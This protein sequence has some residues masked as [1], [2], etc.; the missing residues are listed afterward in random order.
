M[1]D[2]KMWMKW[3][4]PVTLIAF[5]I[6]LTMDLISM[7]LWDIM[8]HGYD[9]S[10]NALV[11]GWNIANTGLTLAMGIWLTVSGRKVQVKLGAL[12]AWIILDAVVVTSYLGAV[13]FYMAVAFCIPAM[14]SFQIAWS[15]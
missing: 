5:F 11:P 10:P 14:Y 12:L 13:I 9:Y 15:K 6:L 8:C 7:F 1:C 2:P 3:G 4:G